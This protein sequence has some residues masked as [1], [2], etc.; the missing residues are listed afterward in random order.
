MIALILDICL[1]PILSM[2]SFKS[3]I[4][5]NCVKYRDFVRYF[6]TDSKFIVYIQV[7]YVVFLA[8]Y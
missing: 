3:M 5:F 7:F 1:V 6:F 4:I 2:F 8:L